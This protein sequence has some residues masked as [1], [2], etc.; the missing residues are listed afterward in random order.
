MYSPAVLPDAKTRRVLSTRGEGVPVRAWFCTN[1]VTD[2][3]KLYPAARIRIAFVPPLGEVEDCPFCSETIMGSTGERV[4]RVFYTMARAEKKCEERLRERDFEV[5]LP[6]Y[7]ALRQWKDRKKKVVE[8]LFRNYIFARVN[9]RER[10]QVLEVDG[11]VRTV[12]FGGR[13][14]EVAVHEIEQLQIALRD[15]ERL[16]LVDFP[17]PATGTMV[18]VTDGPLRGLEGEV[19]EHR[20][21]EYVVVRV[22]AIQQAVRVTL[23]GQWLQVLTPESAA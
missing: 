21:Q 7:I 23:P 19:T 20:G 2:V 10:L 14:A 16:G 5:L 1:R 12:S 18:K 11:I 6:K 8:P 3:A 4:W 15:P 9:E 17:L 13:L 22:S